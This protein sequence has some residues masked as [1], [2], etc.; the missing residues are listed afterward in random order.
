M[1]LWLL[2][3]WYNIC[4]IFRKG[5]FARLVQRCYFDFYFIAL[6]GYYLQIC[7]LCWED[8]T[9][10]DLG[11]YPHKTQNGILSNCKN[12]NERSEYYQKKMIGTRVVEASARALLRLKTILLGVI[13][14]LRRLFDWHVNGFGPFTPRILFRIVEL[15]C[16]D[17]S[18]ENL[19]YAR[20]FVRGLR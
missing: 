14:V 13:I 18:K 8:V 10:T 16:F 2:F 17:V 4:F 19:V 11:C 15:F 3:H 7:L 5:A 20:R 1:L 9:S 12:V 6:G